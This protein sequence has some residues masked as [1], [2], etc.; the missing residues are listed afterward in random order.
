MK[1]K[2]K[3]YQKKN[4]AFIVYRYDE[5]KNDFQYVKE[6]YSTKE[7]Q[8]DFKIE[9]VRQYTT[10]TIEK[11]RHLIENKYVVIKEEI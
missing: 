7:I 10:N 3:Y 4:Y 2:N 6:Y 1:N 5:F 8:H 11:V 9:N